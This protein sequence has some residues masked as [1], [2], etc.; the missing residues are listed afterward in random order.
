MNKLIKFTSIGHFP[1]V[2]ESIKYAS[3]FIKKDISGNPVFDESLPIPTVTYIGRP[4]LHGTCSS[5]SKKDQDA[6]IQY[7]SKE[8]VVTV[9][10]DNSGYAKSMDQVPMQIKEMLFNIVM[11]CAKS[12][13]VEIKWPITIFGEFCHSKISKKVAIQKCDPMFVIFSIRMGDDV[14]LGGKPLGWVDVEL[15][16]SVKSDVFRIFNIATFPSYEIKID[17]GNPKQALNL[18]NEYTLQV[19]KECPVGKQFGVVGA[20]EGL[21]WIPKDKFKDHPRYWFKTK[22]KTHKQNKTRTDTE[23]SSEEQEELNTVKDIV[24]EFLVEQRLERGI[25]YLNESN[26]PLSKSSTGVFVAFVSGDICKDANK[27]M[28]KADVT[29]KQIKK[30]SS[31]IISKWF[32]RRLETVVGL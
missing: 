19:D 14:D 21:V 29:A 4:K 32:L 24:E 2:V 15:F 13:G 18:L 12:N 30:H 23:L 5:L 10:R 27:D 1:D 9:E 20:G 26:N 3:Q 25:A 31:K 6:P 11:D 8:M 28:I 17:F 16:K 22:G 7:Q